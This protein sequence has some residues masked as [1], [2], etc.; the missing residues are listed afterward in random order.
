MESVY[1]FYRD[2]REATFLTDMLKP[3]SGVLVSD[4]FTGYDSIPCQQ[5]KCLIH[6]LRD[7]NEDVFRHPFDKELIELSHEFATLLRKVVLTIDR[8]GLQSRHLRGHRVEVDAFFAKARSG[9]AQSDLARGYQKRF[10]KYQDRLFAFLDYDGVP[11]N[12]NNA[13]HAIHCF[14]RYRTFADGLFTEASIQD[15]LVLLS[16]YQSCEYQGINFL[17]YLRNEKIEGRK[18]LSAGMRKRVGNNIAGSSASSRIQP[19]ML[20]NAE[21]AQEH[22]S[23]SGSQGIASSP[24]ENSHQ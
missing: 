22:A 11:W 21:S 10:E 2:S 20:P 1:F 8:N 6:L 9:E 4:F 17:Q 15:Y 24:L 3:F 19:V 16:L 23:Q 7:L 12:N 18:G 13:E 5:Q 14:A